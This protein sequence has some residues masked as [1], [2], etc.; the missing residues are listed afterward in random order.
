MSCTDTAHRVK[1]RPSPGSCKDHIGHE[2]PGRNMRDTQGEKGTRGTSATM[3]DHAGPCGTLRLDASYHPVPGRAHHLAPI[4]QQ[5]A[6]PYLGTEAPHSPW[7]ATPSRLGTEAP[8]SPW[9][10]CRVIYPQWIPQSLTGHN[11][12]LPHQ[13]S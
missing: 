2:G 1:C 4:A 7:P 6:P 11:F 12:R 9:R 13:R 3:Q 5:S 10:G 8:C